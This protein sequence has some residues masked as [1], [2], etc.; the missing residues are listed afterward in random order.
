[1]EHLVVDGRKILQLIFRKYYGTA[2]PAVFNPY[3]ANVE[4]RVS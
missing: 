4:Y 2:W 3:P 1:L